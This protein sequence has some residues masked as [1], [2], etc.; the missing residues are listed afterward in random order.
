MEV[1]NLNEATL[2]YA[3]VAA[4]A[5]SA[6]KWLSAKGVSDEILEALADTVKNIHPE[7]YCAKC[8]QFDFGQTGEH[9][10]PDCGTPIIWDDVEK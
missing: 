7:N 10:C 4:M 8:K 5:V 6:C 9:R 1:K 3:G 2:F